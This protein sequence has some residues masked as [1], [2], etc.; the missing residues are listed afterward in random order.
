VAL[1][2]SPP[3]PDTTGAISHVTVLTP[4]L[5]SR[6]RTLD[7][8][9]ERWNGNS[10]FARVPALHLARLTILDDLRGPRGRVPLDPAHLVFAATVDGSA[11]ELPG[12]LA[13]LMGDSCDELWACCDGYPGSADTAAFGAYLQ[14]HRIV[15][16]LVFATFTASVSEIRDAL[17]L[18]AALGR[19]VAMGAAMDAGSLRAAVEALG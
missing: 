7:A 15:A 9:L 3:P 5:P 11:N 4:V 10:P 16:E 17:A 1:I 8:L 13:A 2:S 12:M 19:I 18:Q 6:R 14:A